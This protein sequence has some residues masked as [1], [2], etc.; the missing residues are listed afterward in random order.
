MTSNLPREH[1]N[2]SIETI[3]LLFRSVADFRGVKTIGVVL[4]VALDDGS[5][6]LAAIHHAGG[7]T[8]VLRPSSNASH[9]MPEN[10]IAF[11]GPVS[12]IGNGGWL[13]SEI[14]RLVSSTDEPPL[15][16]P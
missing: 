12:V 1:W 9:G 11:D 13:A 7:Q 16:M 2:Q 15:A 6:G 4:L 14:I 5:R 8:M 10:A 3:D